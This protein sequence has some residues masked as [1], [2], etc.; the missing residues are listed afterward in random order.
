MYRK[1]VGWI[2]VHT[3]AKKRGA[4]NYPHGLTQL[5]AGQNRK[6]H[7][8]SQTKC[9]VRPVHGM[10]VCVAEVLLLCY[11]LPYAFTPHRTGEEQKE[12]ARKKRI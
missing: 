10:Y 7:L 11:L 4:I 12:E 3:E 2:L 9:C 8:L 6:M 1:I 5:L